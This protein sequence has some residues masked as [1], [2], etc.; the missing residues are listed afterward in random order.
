MTVTT[1]DAKTGPYSGNGSTTVFAYDFLILDEGDI[2]VTLTDSSGIETV[3]TITTH[4]TVSGVGETS[5][6]NVTMVTAPA[7]GEKLTLSR[8]TEI[9]QLTDLQN[10]KAVDPETLED[11]LDRLT[12]INQDQNEVLSRAVRIDISS[13]ADIDQFLTDINALAN[14]TSDLTTLAGV[15][16]D[17]T[18]VAGISA[19]VTTVAGISANVTTVAGISADVPTVAGDSADIQTLA[20]VEDGTVSTNAISNLGP[21]SADITTVAGIS[22]DVTT[23]AG[24]S[25]DVTALVTGTGGTLTG[26]WTASG[27]WDFTSTEA[28]RIPVG[29]TA[30]RPGTPATGDLRFS[31]TDGAAEIY[32]GSSW[33]P[34]GGGGLFKGENGEVGTAPGDIFR[35]NEQTLNT[36]TTIDADENASCTGPLTVA[37][38]VTLTVT[39]GG[40]L[41]II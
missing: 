14:I 29:T 2:V 32:N 25:A 36:D 41:A 11:A 8:S 6:G 19:D 34:V 37:S 9:S 7:S 28:L 30:Q 5:G 33:A 35:I 40:T 10:R 3:Q 24:I 39:S 22:S 38:G 31:S 20:D 18:T 27:V 16:S 21:I 13:S 12:L 15:S 26:D 17:I 4:Y 23:V 1:N